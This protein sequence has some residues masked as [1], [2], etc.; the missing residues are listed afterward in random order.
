MAIGNWLWDKKTNGAQIS[1]TG[2]TVSAIT[3]VSD[4]GRALEEKSA[5]GHIYCDTKRLPYPKAVIKDA[6]ITILRGAED[7]QFRE[8]VKVGLIMLSDWQ[9]GVEEG[10]GKTLLNY[11]ES[12]GAPQ[13][14][15]A[16]SKDAQEIVKWSEIAMSESQRVKDELVA[17]GL[18]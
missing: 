14:L 9:D 13:D 6:L 8:Q 18:W 3:I 1:T 5:S 2:P 11:D 7:P 12:T 17:E 10:V 16:M 4:Y 15:E